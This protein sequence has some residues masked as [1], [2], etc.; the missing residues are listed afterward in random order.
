MKIEDRF[1]FA[2]NYLDEAKKSFD[3]GK[4]SWCLLCLS[5]ANYHIDRLYIDL[6]K[7]VLKNCG[8]DR[9]GTRSKQ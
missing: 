9:P 3:A 8:P 6:H 7:R 4:V 1:K 5:D 2:K